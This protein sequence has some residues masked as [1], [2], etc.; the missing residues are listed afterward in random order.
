MG[1]VNLFR[2]LNS[3]KEIFNFNG[4]LKDSL[5]LDWDNAEILK[6]GE[7]LTP[8][9]ELKE[10]EILIIQEFPGSATALLA[11]SIVLAVVSLGVG[12]GAGIYASEQA[13]RA[14]R[15]M[16]E[17]LKRIGKTNKQKDV[18][19]IPQ[20]ADARNEKIDGKN[21]PIFLGKHLFAPYFLSEPYMRPGGTDGEDL[22]WYGTFLVGQSG[23]CFEKIRNGTI[24]LVTF[25][26]ADTEPQRGKINFVE[27]GDY[28]DP[29]KGRYFTKRFPSTGAYGANNNLAALASDVNAFFGDPYPTNKTYPVDGGMVNGQTLTSVTVIPD[30]GGMILEFITSGGTFRWRSPS[31]AGS[32]YWF[33]LKRENPN[34][35]IPPFYDP[36]NF[37][38]IVQKGNEEE[39][40]KFGTPVFEEKWAD[41]LE[42]TVE[43]GRKK[44]KGAKSVNENGRPDENG[45]YLDDDGEEPVERPTARFPMRAEI[46]IFFP[47]GLYSWDTKNGEET[48]ASVEIRLEWS[49]DGKEWTLIPVNFNQGVNTDTVIPA[50][51]KIQEYVDG[52]LTALGKYTINLPNGGRYGTAEISPGGKVELEKT[53]IGGG[54]AYRFRIAGVADIFV[55][56][57]SSTT[58]GKDLRIYGAAA[59]DKITRRSSKQ[60]RF[61]VEVDFPPEVYAK[62]GDPVFIRAVRK[63]RMHT[64]TYRSR[65]YLSAIR[66]KQYNPDTSSTAELKAAKNINEEVADKFCRMGIKI[67][68]NKNTQDYMDRFNVIASMTGRIALCDYA[69]GRWA[70]NGKWSDK[71]VKTSNSAAVL[72]ELITG[73]IHEPSRHKD[74]EVDFKSF[75]KLYEY[76]MNRKVEIK[77]QGLQNFVL[78]CNGVLTSGTRK[79]DA[80]TSVLATC[81]AG[82]Y[83]D[84]FGKLEVY[85]EDTQTTPIALL[86]PQ[87][88]VSMVNQK[89]LERKSDGYVLEIVDQESDYTQQTYK[90]LRPFITE[91]PGETSY[92][93]MKLDFTTSYNQAMWHAR[94][95][96]AKEEHRP[97]EL[98]VTVGKEGRYYKPGS[99]IKVQH[100]RHKIGLGSGEIVQLVRDGNKI[101]GLKLM[102][103]FDISNE[104]D[105]WVE[106]FVVGDKPR[107]VTKQIKSVGR[108]TDTLMFTAEMDINSPDV[109][110]FGNILSAMYGESLNTGRVWEAKRYIVTDLSE[111]DD[112]Y[113][114]ALAEY[115]ENIYET[116]DIEERR[117]SIL[118]APPLVLTDQRASELEEFWEAQRVNGGPQA[119]DRIADGVFWRNWDD[120]IDQGVAERTAR[121]RGVVYQAGTSTG[122]TSLGQMNLDDW[123]YYA[124]SNGTWQKDYVY[125]WTATGWKQRLRPSQDPT[126]GWLYLD[127][128]S[129]SDGITTGAD[130]GIFSDV[131]CK[132]IVA[133]TAFIEYL[134]TKNAI[135]KDGGSIRS[136][137]YSS[138]SG[139]II[140]SSG[141]VEFWNG[142][143]AGHIDAKSGFFTN[144]AGTNL[145]IQGGTINIGPLFV[146]DDATTPSQGKTYPANTTLVSFMNEYLP[147]EPQHD[148]NNNN[149][150]SIY[151]TLAIYYGGKLGSWDLYS[152]TFTKTWIYRINSNDTEEK[153]EYTVEFN[154]S[155]GKKTV[156]GSSAFGNNLNVQI[157]YQVVING[158]GSGSTFKLTN[159]PTSGTGQSGTLWRD[160]SDGNVIRI[161]P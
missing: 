39:L 106:Y 26:S 128:V 103:K 145:N 1:V 135:I 44:K 57:G 13:K 12:I 33:Q 142:K 116:G 161:V 25:P 9:Y 43:L 46:E 15:D 58:L 21:V 121:F 132:A 136:Q 49:K 10:N 119:V 86:N 127:A 29:D 101:T 76:C 146:S 114:L 124:G 24:D 64:G 157:G 20:L 61:L 87:R 3:E 118:S 37:L 105:Y 133:A 32:S 158:G 115:A 94:R 154:T 139:F 107:V 84:E 68:A 30:G 144:I 137:T 85:F 120:N 93:P 60:M 90:I 129:S 97:G 74:E 141:D 16:E 38:E 112:G 123:V 7:K 111:N 53:M 140:K 4:R 40:N 72:L 89:S 109:P 28:N 150:I 42:S 153:T 134:Y 78:E 83:I 96:L 91:K 62:S 19:T 45:I 110:A 41:S 55:A 51:T 17:A 88:I 50:S 22:Y 8:D 52:Y 81:D 14:Q 65:V 18:T 63:T 95:L 36:E 70:W 99:L 160:L 149:E 82:I 156:A 143:F 138:D 130:I 92:S 152:I 71:K 31:P 69:E 104:R 147:G 108:Y 27:A 75:G 73:L 35:T 48:Y 126:Y 5:D 67:K 98:K 56:A 59:T 131:F 79:T 151:R 80:M 125:Q 54:R 113:D 11:T 159:L 2:G 155:G 6:N 148:Y 122:M 102:E 100:E 77:D 47:E 66:T 34:F 23:L 117:S